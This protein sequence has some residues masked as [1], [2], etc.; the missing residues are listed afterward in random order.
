MKTS[1]TDQIDLVGTINPDFRNVENQV[2][3]VDFSYFERLAG[4]F[5]RALKRTVEA[6]VGPGLPG[7]PSERAL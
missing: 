1:L 6:D 2:L 7:A 5:L 3:S 4:E